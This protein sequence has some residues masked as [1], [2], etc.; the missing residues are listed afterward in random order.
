MGIGQ[1]NALIIIGVLFAL[2]IALVRTR[3]RAR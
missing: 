2:W 3:P 1:S